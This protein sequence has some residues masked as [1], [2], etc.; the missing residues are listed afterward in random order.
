MCRS[1]CPRQPLCPLKASGRSL[2]PQRP[3][4]ACCSVPWP[5]CCPVLRACPR[6]GSDAACSRPPP[7]R[8]REERLSPGHDLLTFPLVQGSGGSQE[9]SMELRAGREAAVASPRDRIPSY[10]PSH[11]SSQKFPSHCRS[12]DPWLVSEQTYWC[13][14][15]AG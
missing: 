7:P 12:H 5:P 2:P 10:R 14:F 1:E 15:S 13:F 9:S 4:T 11:S 3:S 6:Q 8:D